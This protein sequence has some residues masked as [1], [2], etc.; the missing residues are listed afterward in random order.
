MPSNCIRL[1]CSICLFLREEIFGRWLLFKGSFRNIVQW[2]N[3]VYHVLECV[4]ICIYWLVKK[5]FEHIVW[6]PDQ[7]SV[8]TSPQLLYTFS[9]ISYVLSEFLQWKYNHFVLYIIHL[10]NRFEVKNNILLHCSLSSTVGTYGK[11]TFYMDIYT[12]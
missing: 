5:E 11:F 2:L 3:C 7:S 8:F 9:E 4:F 1:E 12:Y 10:K 6:L